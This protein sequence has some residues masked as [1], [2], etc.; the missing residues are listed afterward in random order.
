MKKFSTIE[1]IVVENNSSQKVVIFLQKR[2]VGM[3]VSL[4]LEYVLGMVVTL[5]GASPEDPEF[6]H[7]PLLA[8]LAFDIHA[9][10]G[11]SIFIG[12]VVILIK[13]TKVKTLK[14]TR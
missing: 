6:A 14:S 13:G 2:T 12:A 10:L 8:K 9:L 1:Y 11:L 3:L 4:S 5:F 7:K